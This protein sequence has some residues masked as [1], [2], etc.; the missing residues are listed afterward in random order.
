MTIVI[1]TVA[2]LTMVI[3]TYFSKKQLD[4][5]T[6]DELF[7]GQLFTI[8]ALLLTEKLRKML[9]II[10]FPIFVLQNSILKGS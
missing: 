10:S 4:N 5:S 1:V 3:V 6:T 9:S 8:L 7:S 2:V